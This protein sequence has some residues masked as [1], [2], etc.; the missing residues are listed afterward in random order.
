[1]NHWIARFSTRA[2]ELKHVDKHRFLAGC[3]FVAVFIAT[4]IL[5][6]QDV[7]GWGAH[8]HWSI[9]ILLF[10]SLIAGLAAMGGAI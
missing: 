4:F 10:L 9:R 1:M 2:I 6:R 7:M 8:E 3:V 5:L